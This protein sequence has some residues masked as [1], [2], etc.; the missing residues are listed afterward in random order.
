MGLKGG[1]G[2]G[3]S[4]GIIGLICGVQRGRRNVPCML[5]N[6]RPDALAHLLL[7]A[8]KVASQPAVNSDSFSIAI[9]CVTWRWGWVYYVVAAESMSDGELVLH[10]SLLQ[11]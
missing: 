2:S 3:C 9:F 7:E 5:R 1:L 11:N 4:W 8:W 6:L 10:F